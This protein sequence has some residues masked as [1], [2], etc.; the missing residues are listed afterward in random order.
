MGKRKE[1]NSEI[2]GFEAMVERNKSGTY[3]A[4]RKWFLFVP[5]EKLAH[6]SWRYSGFYVTEPGRGIRSK[7][8]SAKGRKRMRVEAKSRLKRG[9][10]E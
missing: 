7:G 8:K 6:Y 5:H 3:S 1:R 9:S 10:K 2:V 4:T